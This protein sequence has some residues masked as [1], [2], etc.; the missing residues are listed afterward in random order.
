MVISGRGGFSTGGFS[1]W[2]AL[3]P[4]HSVMVE[5]GGSHTISSPSQYKLLMI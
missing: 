2:S 4:S 1:I 5:S 3:K